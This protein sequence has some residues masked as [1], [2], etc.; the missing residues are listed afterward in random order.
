MASGGT[1]IR[2]YVGALKDSTTVGIAKVN[3]DYKRL[4]IAIVKATN[5]VESPAKEKYIRDI[6]GHLSA[7]RAQADVAYCIRA[8]ARRLSKTRNWAKTEI[9]GCV[10]LYIASIFRPWILGCTQDI[11]CHTPCPPRG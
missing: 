4:D 9:V 10:G 6:F 11:N 5:H 7:G 3:S 1:S 8:L 2:R